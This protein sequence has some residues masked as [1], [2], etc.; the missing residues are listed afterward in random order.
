MARVL[1]QLYDTIIY[2]NICETD[3]ENRMFVAT[4]AIEKTK[5]FILYPNPI[6]GTMILN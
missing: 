1:L 4:N 2:E 5:P 3:G 6:N